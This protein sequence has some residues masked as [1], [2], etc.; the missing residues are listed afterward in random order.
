MPQNGNTGYWDQDKTDGRTSHIPV[1]LL[2][3]RTPLTFKMEGLATGA[4]DYITKPFSMDILENRVRNL[5]DSRKLLRERYS[6]EIIYS[7]IISPL[8]LQTKSF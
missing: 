7:P 6:K 2:T 5:I 8:L 4:D 1:I 3:A